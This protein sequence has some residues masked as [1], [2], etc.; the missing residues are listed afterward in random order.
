MTGIGLKGET[1]TVMKYTVSED[2]NG[3]I[4]SYCHEHANDT[5]N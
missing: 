5:S 2:N 4:G 3:A 1:N